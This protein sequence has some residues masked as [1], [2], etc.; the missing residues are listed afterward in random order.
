MHSECVMLIFHELASVLH[1]TYMACLVNITENII[2]YSSVC[3]FGRSALG[4]NGQLVS[5]SLQNDEPIISDLI[6]QIFCLLKEYY[7]DQWLIFRQ[8]VCYSHSSEA[9]RS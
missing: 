4:I 1:Y 5:L 7:G 2:V 8:V 3:V 6:L 9:F